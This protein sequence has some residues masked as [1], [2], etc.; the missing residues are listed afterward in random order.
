VR[1]CVCENCGQDYLASY[2][3]QRWCCAECRD[4]YRNAEL[5]AARR[6]W[7]QAG[8][9]KAVLEQCRAREVQR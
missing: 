9:P 8:K 7:A 5:R 3:T 6:V 1:S 4:E 2:P